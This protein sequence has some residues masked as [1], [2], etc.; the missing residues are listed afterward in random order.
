MRT[1]RLSIHTFAF[2]IGRVSRSSGTR[3][4]LWNG[5]ATHLIRR[6]ATRFAEFERRNR[7][8]RG[9]L[10]SV[11]RPSLLPRLTTRRQIVE[12]K[13]HRDARSWRAHATGAPSHLIYENI[14]PIDF[15]RCS[16]A[17]IVCVT[18]V[19]SGELRKLGA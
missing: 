4:T 9:T 13:P 15:D 11:S 14:E 17:D 8:H 10:R 3:L 19:N 18:G 7:T 2:T 5:A 1:D 6:W 12:R 16:R